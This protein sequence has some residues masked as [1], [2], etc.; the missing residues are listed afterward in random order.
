MTGAEFFISRKQMHQEQSENTDFAQ[1]SQIKTSLEVHNLKAQFCKSRR[2]LPAL[3]YKQRHLLPISV[4]LCLRVF[5][6]TTPSNPQKVIN[7][8]G[9]FFLFLIMLL[10][11]SH[12]PWPNSK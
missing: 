10:K 3:L 7:K 12:D 2:S 5:T 1:L 11:C 4:A 9:I 8:Q 6:T